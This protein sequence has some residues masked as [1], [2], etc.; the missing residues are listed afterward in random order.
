MNVQEL[1]HQRREELRRSIGEALASSLQHSNAFI[2]RVLGEQTV[3][4]LHTDVKLIDPNAS[5]YDARYQGY[6]WLAAAGYTLGACASRPDALV[7]EFRAGLARLQQRVGYSQDMLAGDDIGLLGIADGIY[8]LSGHVDTEIQAAHAWLLKLLHAPRRSGT[9]SSRLRELA[10]DLLDNRGH[11]QVRIDTSDIQPFAPELV[12]RAIW[13]QA[14]QRVPPFGQREREML[15]RLLLTQHNIPNEAEEAAVWLRCLD[16]LVDEA[17]A[18]LVSSV[19]DT[20]RVLINIQHGLKRWVWREKSRRQ[21]TLPSRWQIDDECDVQSLLWMV[22][23]PIYGAELVDEQYLP[24][25]GQVQPRVDLGIKSLKLIIEVKI[26]RRIS[27]FAD[28]EE[29]VAG[30][31]GLYFKDITLFDRMIVFVYDDCDKYCPEKYDSLRNAL[32]QRQRIEEVVIVR[33]PG[34]LPN[35]DDRNG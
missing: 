10:A 21:N 26:A 30:D 23:Y 28:I 14:F 27:D 33:R 20:T 15:A 32:K 18:N 35:R 9:W 2:V 19:S 7:A 22:L 16:I 5:T 8:Q 11:L 29:Q 6:P 4:A 24:S 13:P 12:L 17:S 34:M 31:L 1:L 25:Y 3:R